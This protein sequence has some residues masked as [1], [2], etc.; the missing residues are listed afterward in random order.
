VES[1]IVCKYRKEIPEQ[2]VSSGFTVAQAQAIYH[3]WVAPMDDRNRFVFLCM[4]LCGD[5]A[6]H[7]AL[8]L[9]LLIS[10]KGW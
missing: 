5:I 6:L 7:T 10:S 2:L 9:R 8:G 1:R 3:H 4:V